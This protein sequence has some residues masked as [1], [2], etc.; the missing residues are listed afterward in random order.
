MAGIGEGNRKGSRKRS[1]SESDSDKISGISFT[2]DSP[3]NRNPDLDIDPDHS[4]YRSIP[5]LHS[6]EDL[7]IETP[8]GGVEGYPTPSQEIGW[9]KRKI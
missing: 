7:Y 6:P 5:N 4:N 2:P 3:T 8:V 1:C 9:I